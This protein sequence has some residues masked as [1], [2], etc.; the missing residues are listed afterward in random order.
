MRSTYRILIVGYAALSAVSACGG[1]AA[2]DGVKPTT[3]FAVASDL[4]GMKLVVVGKDIWTSTDGGSTWTNQTP[5]GPAHNHSWTSVA[6]DSKGMKLVA[7]ANGARDGLASASTEEVNGDIWTSTDGGVTWTDQTPSGPAHGQAW[8]SVASD[9]V[10]TNLVAVTPG[11]GVLGPGAIWTSTDAGATWTNQTAGVHDMVPSGWNTVASDST[12]TKLVAATNGGDIWT[13]TNGGVAWTDR[14]SSGPA[15]S[16]PNAI[17]GWGWASVASDS[18]GD[19]LVAVVDAGDIWTSTNA[20][21][22]WTDQMP[23]GPA[24]N[25]VWFS[26]A[27]D[28]TGTNLVAVDALVTGNNGDIWTST[29]GGVTWTDRTKGNAALSQTWLAVTSSAT[30]SHIVAVGPGVV[31][32]N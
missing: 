2:G 7:V 26:V 11:Q 16:P 1:G 23:S 27:S 4:T 6:S 17:G 21:L 12:G 24:S 14:T 5:S 9:S 10:G 19:R 15:H 3:A 22:T 32:T 18:T 20:G 31:W 8:F 25:Q 13:S 28:S 29:D 30:G